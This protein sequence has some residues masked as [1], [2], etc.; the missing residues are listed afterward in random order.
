[1]PAHADLFRELASEGQTLVSAHLLARRQRAGATV[2]FTGDPDATIEKVLH[3][4]D[5]VWIDKN[6]SSGFRG[7]SRDVWLFRIG[8]YQIAE[9]WLKARKGRILGERDREHYGQIV[10]G[11][12]Q[13]MAGM[14]AIDGV[15]DRYGGW[16]NA[17][18]ICSVGKG[19]VPD[20]ELSKQG[21]KAGPL[22]SAA[23]VNVRSHSR[24]R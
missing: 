16:P 10:V 19:A 18:A 7:V 5:T 6:K 22:A 14:K 21:S 20:T 15:I 23:G 3:E 8:G 13:T 24:A 1:M 4:S 2:E 9:K 17:F 11:L 12:S